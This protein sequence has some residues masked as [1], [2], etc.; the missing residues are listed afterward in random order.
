MFHSRR[1]VLAILVSTVSVA[2]GCSEIDFSRKPPQKSTTSEADILLHNFSETAIA[3]RIRVNSIRSGSELLSEDFALEDSDLKRFQDPIKEKTESV[4]VT[5][6]IESRPLA[7][8]QW[9]PPIEDE[10]I[11]S[12]KVSEKDI[13]FTLIME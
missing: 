12:I 13:E 11:L 3:G 7:T 5:V 4:E 1:H 6:D 8:F 2:S 10:T 9:E